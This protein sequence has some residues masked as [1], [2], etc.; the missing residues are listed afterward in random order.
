MIIPDIWTWTVIKF[1]GSKAPIRHM[2][3]GSHFLHVWI[4]TISSW[5]IFK[6]NYIESDR[7]EKNDSSSRFTVSPDIISPMFFDHST[8]QNYLAWPMINPRPKKRPPL[9]ITQEDACP[10]LDIQCLQSIYRYKYIYIYSFIR[11]LYYAFSYLSIYWL[12][13]LQYLFNVYK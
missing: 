13:Y 12:I 3:A 10:A 9:D 7:D 11:L 6:A 4:S 2:F 1:H 5:K 8:I